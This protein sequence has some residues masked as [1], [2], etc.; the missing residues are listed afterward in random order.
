MAV[1]VVCRAGLLT[2][3]PEVGV[4]LG[5]GTVTGQIVGQYVLTCAHAD[6]QELTAP[7]AVVPGP[8]A[9]LEITELPEVVADESSVRPVVAAAD[10]F[11]N[12]VAEPEL[13]WTFADAE[14]SARGRFDG[15]VVVEGSGWSDLIATEAES[16]VQARRLLG[17]DRHA[18]VI[19]VEAPERGLITSEEAVGVSGT[20]SDDV[21][22]ASL[23]LNGEAI[24]A[25]EEGRF[26]QAFELGR[27]G[28]DIVSLEV[29]DRAERV[30]RVRTSVL[31]GQFAAEVQAV[32]QAARFRLNPTL[33]SDDDDVDDDLSS[34]I[35]GA[36]GDLPFEASGTATDCNGR[37]NLNALRH[38]APELTVTAVDGGLQT[39][40]VV[41]DVEVDY[42]GRACA[43]FFGCQ[44]ADLDA[45]ATM[46]IEALAVSTLTAEACE[47]VV[48]TEVRSA[49][50]IGLEL[51]DPSLGGTV[52]NL[53]RPQIVSRLEADLEPA[54]QTLVHEAVSTA[55]GTIGLPESL[56][57][58][59]PLDLI[60]Q[61]G[62]CTTG[63]L[64]DETGGHFDQSAMPAAGGALRLPGA[65]PDLSGDHDLGFALH[66]NL[67]NQLLHHIW[68]EDAE[69]V[70]VAGGEVD[71]LLPPVLTPPRPEGPAEAFVMTMAD[72]LA[73]V[74]SQLGPLTI[75]G[76]LQVLMRAEVRQGTVVLAATEDPE[77]I[78]VYLDLVDGPSIAA[79]D[80]LGGLDA[81]ARARFVDAI[82]GFELPI[83]LPSLALVDGRP[84][85]SLADPAAGPDGPD[86]DHLAVRAGLAPLAPPQ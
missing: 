62:P 50:V 32:A 72:S 26:G 58:P 85:L 13:E 55:V 1:A 52:E 36:L 61:L 71:M 53:L 45:T 77:E 11:D 17:V 65:T 40:I 23:T 76:T 27:P 73:T 78:D 25:D 41:P 15:S 18:P 14:F 24:E 10:A 7:L 54:V 19:V 4:V 8:V 48:V 28:V 37:I 82:A 86:H 59:P 83:P 22:V 43:D 6:G 34:L 31:H 12:V 30:A 75:A 39:E 81:L 16:S 35:G 47:V 44:C 42:D 46:R 79:I 68:S 38:G 49:D 74:D 3:A 21:G 63:V 66:L 5:E 20:I 70:S 80:A 57:L 29:T 56:A 2:V 67:I 60:V 69:L 84:P 33:L 64:F 51:N 9:T